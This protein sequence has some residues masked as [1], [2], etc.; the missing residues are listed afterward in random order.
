VSGEHLKKPADAAAGELWTTSNVGWPLVLVQR[1]DSGSVVVEAV[2]GHSRGMT[3]RF[4]LGEGYRDLQLVA[5][6]G[7]IEDVLELIHSA[8]DLVSREAEGEDC[9]RCG[10]RMTHG[11]RDV[12][13]ECKGSSND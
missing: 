10:R 7:T 9:K 4:Y 12:C 2:G 5:F 13:N 6:V 11:E 1:R 3:S 8:A